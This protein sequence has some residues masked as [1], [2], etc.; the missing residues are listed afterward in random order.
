MIRL[1]LTK[2]LDIESN[3]VTALPKEIGQMTSLKWLL[4]DYNNISTLPEQIG[5]MK[6]IERL[7]V[8][9][10]NVVTIPQ[11]VQWMPSLKFFWVENN[12][13]MYPTSDD[14]E[15]TTYKVPSLQVLE[16]NIYA[17]NKIGSLLQVNY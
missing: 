6:Q 13:L 15:I 9:F 4:A 2:G 12:P 11:Q 1:H 8:D 14:F 5:D 3:H 17:H 10:N 16:T 7:F